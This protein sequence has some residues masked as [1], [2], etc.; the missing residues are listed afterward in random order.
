MA[1][2]IIALEE[3]S[4]RLRQLTHPLLGA[5]T[6]NVGV[7][8]GGTQVNIVPESCMI[9]IDRRLLPGESPGQVWQEYRAFLESLATSIPGLEVEAE[10]PM[11]QDLP[12]ETEMSEA[13]VT[14][15]SRVL[16]ELGLDPDPAGVPY[17]S[18]A[19]KLAAVGIPSIVFGPGSID[20]AHAAVEYVDCEEV[21]LAEQF[22][23]KFILSF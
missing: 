11:L 6:F 17:G 21:R 22:Y 2:V 23:R 4:E 20:Q 13:V 10:T 12:L 15:A 16:G 8:Q 14:V 19:S 18:D 1:R 3:N 7:V 5:A 9:E